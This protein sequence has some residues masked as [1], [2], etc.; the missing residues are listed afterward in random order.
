MQLKTYK[1]AICD[2][3][4]R[5]KFELGLRGSTSTPK[6]FTYVVRFF[7]QELTFKH[8]NRKL[9]IGKDRRCASNYSLLQYA[10]DVLNFSLVFVMRI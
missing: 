6:L 1:S 10:K 8:S 7:E 2:R 9:E 4:V 5:R 3:S